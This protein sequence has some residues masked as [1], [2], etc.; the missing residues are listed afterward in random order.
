M[1]AKEILD[2]RLPAEAQVVLAT[3]NSHKLME[4]ESILLPLVPGLRPGGIVSSAGLGL[5]EAVEDGVTFSQNALKKAL[6]IAAHVSLPVLADDSGICVDV[7]G[8]APGVFSARWCGKHG[9][10]EENI[11]L[12]LSQLADVRAEHRRAAFVCAAALLT[13][14]GSQMVKIGKMTGTLLFE[15]SGLQGFGYD[16]IFQADGYGVSNAELPPGVKNTISHRRAAFAD[17][18]PKIANL[19]T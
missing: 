9:S 14:D 15:R 10:D 18:A 6:H 12:L 7:L 11:D 8:G 2:Y 17:L 19:L 3:G 4:I 5:G 13:P 1:T 16:P